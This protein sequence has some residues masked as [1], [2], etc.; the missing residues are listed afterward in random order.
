MKNQEAKEKMTPLLNQQMFE[1]FLTRR[2][3]YSYPALRIIYFTAKWCGPCQSL[4][5]EMLMSITPPTVEWVLVDADDNDYTFGYCGVRT[6][7]SFMSIKHGQ[8]SPIFSSSNM[9]AI[10]DWLRSYTESMYNQ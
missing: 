4:D 7:P 6:I 5:L 1:A 10:I 2:P 9:K 3:D 8:A